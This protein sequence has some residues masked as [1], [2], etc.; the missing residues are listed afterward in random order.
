MPFTEEGMRRWLFLRATEWANWPT[1]VSQPV[2]PI[3]FIFYRWIFV[4]GALFFL[5]LMWAVLRY[6]YVNV[7]AATYAVYFVSFCKWPAAIGSGAYLLY[8]HSYFAGTLALAWPIVCGVVMVPYKVGRLELMFA[9]KTGYAA[10][11]QVE[12]DFGDFR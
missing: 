9:E 3:M 4:V 7:P 2:V 1:F 6:R 11:E 8:H 10:R 5:D 12:A